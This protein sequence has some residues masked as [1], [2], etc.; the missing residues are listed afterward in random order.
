MD[1][2][3]IPQIASAHLREESSKS[4]ATVCYQRVISGKAKDL[5]QVITVPLKTHC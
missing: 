3:L 1:L 4:K 2:T 5:W